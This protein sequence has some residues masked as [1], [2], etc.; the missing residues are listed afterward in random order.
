MK[1]R[2]THFLRFMTY[3]IWR[4]TE[5]EVGKERRIFYY[6]L[7][8]IM[9]TVRRFRVD[10][11]IDRASALTYSTILSI[12]PILAIIFAIGKG[13]GF[14]SMIEMQLRKTF[15]GQEETINTLLNFANSYLSH[16]KSGLF[17]GIGVFLLLWAVINLITNIELNFNS[18][19]QVK[20][21]RSF[22]R[23]FTDYFSLLFLLPLLLL[24][25]SGSSVYLS[26]F[27]KDL[28]EYQLLQPFV[29][30][31]IKLVPI[32]IT[33]FMFTG[34]FI[35]IP[36]TRVKFK[37]AFISGIV[38]GSAFLFFQYL[39]ISGQV[40]VSKYN[41]IYGSFAAIPLF[42]MFLQISWTICLFGVQ[43]T[44]AGQNIT[45]FNFERDTE[46]ISRRYE[47]FVCVLIMSVICKRFD[48]GQQAYTARELSAHYEIPIRLTYKMLYV[49][50]EVGLLH[51]VNDEDAKSEE[52]V[53]QPSV[54][55][56]K[57]TVASVIDAIETHGSE[58]F[59][60]DNEKEHKALW[61]ALTESREKAMEHGRE[62]RVKDL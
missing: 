28:Q 20:K 48:Q 31:L 18:I 59:K 24:L 23:R 4:I 55:I 35:F 41:A 29:K 6:T 45:N 2:F 16:T 62:L 57:I 51:E 8:T 56:H 58:D 53:Y 26:T 27:A 15:E 30:I 46:H 61:Q 21:S 17:V 50:I 5:N 13:F 32:I 38:V 9:V 22:Y 52:I 7:K 1:G 49:L 3:D 42:L 25:S 36:N 19:W 40:W 47:D 37:Y 34:L 39:Y 14:S 54:D 12:V 43:L 44:Y 33:W 10:R 60:I 11:I